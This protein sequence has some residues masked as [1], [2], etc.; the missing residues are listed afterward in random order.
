MNIK[1]KAME[2]FNN[3]ANILINT[4]GAKDLI[5]HLQVLSIFELMFISLIYVI[6]CLFGS[7]FFH[8]SRTSKLVKKDRK[9]AKIDFVFYFFLFNSF[10]FLILTLIMDYIFTLVISF[11]RGI[12]SFLNISFLIICLMGIYIY[13]PFKTHQ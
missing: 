3:G 1:E 12:F 13:L 8:I 5:T 9:E 4:F 11:D 7:V 2:D 6:Y 10:I